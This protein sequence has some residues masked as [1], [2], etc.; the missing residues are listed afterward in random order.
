MTFGEMAFVVLVGFAAWLGVLL[1][2]NGIVN[3]VLWLRDRTAKPKELPR[4]I[5]PERYPGCI[6]CEALDG[7]GDVRQMARH[8]DMEHIGGVRW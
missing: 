4:L 7:M 3:G 5:M 2:V 6:V 8:Q 1:L